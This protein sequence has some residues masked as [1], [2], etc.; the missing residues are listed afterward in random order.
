MEN[1][2]LPYVCPS[3]PPGP[4]PVRLPKHEEAMAPQPVVAV[5]LE[6]HRAFLRYLESKAGD[7]ALA[8]DILQDAFTRN[9]DKIEA[10]GEQPIVPWF[11]RTLRNAVIDR[12]RRR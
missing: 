8:E 2:A 12:Y 9:L 3:T 4:R 5:L 6:N 1:T 11:Y 10:V 7:R